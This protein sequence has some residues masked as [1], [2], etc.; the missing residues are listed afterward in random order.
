MGR[1]SNE[2]YSSANYSANNSGA[3]LGACGTANVTSSIGL[4]EGVLHS[5]SWGADTTGATI[6]VYDNTAAS[7][8][9]LFKITLPTT[10]TPGQVILDYQ[11]KNGL[12]V[13]IAGAT[14]PTI[15]VGYA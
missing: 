2:G 14:T 4:I 9:V 12:T 11:A 10:T 1:Q 7:G 5:V 3:I 8:T 15:S 6:T 13:V